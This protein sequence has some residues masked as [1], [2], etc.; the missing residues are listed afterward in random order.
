MLK[1]TITISDAIKLLNDM[2]CLDSGAVD[3]LMESRVFVTKQ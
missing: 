2:L 1:E 3:N